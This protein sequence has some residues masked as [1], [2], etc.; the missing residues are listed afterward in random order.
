[1]W[2]PYYEGATLGVTPLER[3]APGASTVLRGVTERRGRVLP[4]RTA[5]LMT[6]PL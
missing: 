3:A 4:K 5:I 1:M 2:Y 6:T